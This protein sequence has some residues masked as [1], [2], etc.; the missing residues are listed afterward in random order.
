MPRILQIDMDKVFGHYL[1]D[2]RPN[3]G[4][5][6]FRGEWLQFGGERFP[7]WLAVLGYLL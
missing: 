5:K 4:A 3:N 6:D 2:D 1:I 7:D